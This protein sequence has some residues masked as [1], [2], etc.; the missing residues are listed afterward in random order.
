M[1]RY[2]KSD[3]VKLLVVAVVITCALVTLVRGVQSLLHSRPVGKVRS[4]ISR[5]FPMIGCPDDIIAAIEGLDEVA[6]QLMEVAQ[7][8]QLKAAAYVGSETDADMQW[9]GD[10]VM[11]ELLWLKKKIDYAKED[12]LWDSLE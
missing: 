4:Q 12:C 9:M 8:T 10:S 5:E 2:S 6:S 7:T 11:K 3:W 1:V